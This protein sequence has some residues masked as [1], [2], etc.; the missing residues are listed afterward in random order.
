MKGSIHRNDIFKT[1]QIKISC[2]SRHFYE[3]N[4]IWVLA[5]IHWTN[6][7]GEKILFIFYESTF[8]AMPF[9]MCPDAAQNISNRL[10]IF[11]RLKIL[12]C[13]RP[14]PRIVRRH[15]KDTRFSNVDLCP[16]ETFEAEAREIIL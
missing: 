16:Q 5:L 8:K 12:C 15:F 2:F 9:S 4:L 11:G 1:H 13:M 14:A 7:D 3:V 6:F 10:V